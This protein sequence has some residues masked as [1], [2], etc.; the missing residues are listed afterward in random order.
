[1]RKWL[2][3]YMT[4]TPH[5]ILVLLLAATL[6]GS[7]VHSQGVREQSRQPL[8]SPLAMYNESTAFFGFSMARHGDTLVVGDITDKTERG[9][10]RGSVY[11]HQLVD[12]N[13]LFQQ[14][15][16]APDGGE[17][18]QFGYSVALDDTTLLVSAP[19]QAGEIGRNMGA[20][21]VYQRQSGGWTL[22]EKVTLPGDPATNLGFGIILHLTPEE[23]FVTAPV[24]DRG[25]LHTYAREPG[26]LRWTG[27]IA[28]PDL[29]YGAGFATSVDTEGDWMAV[30]APG[31]SAGGASYRQGSVHLYQRQGTNWT[32]Q[33]RLP[34]PD[35][36]TRR[37]FGASVDLAGNR[38]V[39]GAPHDAAPALGVGEAFVYSRT[40]GSW[41]LDARLVAPDPWTDD[42]FGSRV[43]WIG[44]DIAVSSPYRDSTSTPPGGG[45]HFFRAWSNQWAHV[46]TLPLPA[47]APMVPLGA[48][49]MEQDGRLLV[50]LAR[51]AEV[52][53]WQWGGSQ[54]A[55][56]SRFKQP[57]VGL[58]MGRK[59]T[60]RGNVALV[61][62]DGRL[63][64]FLS[65]T[66]EGWRRSG[67]WANPYSGLL[68]SAP[69]DFAL[70]NG[71][72]ALSLAV[73]SESST[74]RTNEVHLY[75][76]TSAG[77]W[78]LDTVLASPS[79]A[80]GFG[81]RLS[82][83]DTALAVHSFETGQLW[84]YDVRASS[85]DQPL[86]VSAPVTLAAHPGLT[87]VVDG[88]WAALGCEDRSSGGVAASGE[89]L[90][91]R[92]QAGGWTLAGILAVPATWR[93]PYGKL[94]ASLAMRGDRLLVG[95]PGFDRPNGNSGSGA[96][97][98][99]EL[100]S[101]SWEFVRALE[102]SSL[103]FATRFGASVALGDHLA[104]VGAPFSSSPSAS[105]GH[106]GWVDVYHE[107]DGTWRHQARF[108]A[109]TDVWDNFGQSI[110]LD[111]LNLLVGAPYANTPEV[112]RRGA[113]H[114]L[115]LS[116]H[117][118]L[119]LWPAGVG[120]GQPW[121]ASSTG[122]MLHL[123]GV[124]GR[125]S[126]HTV[127]VENTGAAPLPL[128][129]L[130]VEAGSLSAFSSATPGATNLAPN[131]SA[132]IELAFHPDRKGEYRSRLAFPSSVTFPEGF[133]FWVAGTAILPVEAWRD[134]H[135]GTQ[136][137]AGEAADDADPDGDGLANLV[138][139]AIGLHP[140]YHDV[141]FL[142]HFQPEPLGLRLRFPHPPDVAGIRYLAET[143]AEIS[144]TEWEP[145]TDLGTADFHE[146]FLPYS[147]GIRGFLRLRVAVAAEVSP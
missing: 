92:R 138:E 91:A 25:A 86:T 51:T 64:H 103:G 79:P 139:F 84:M 122:D 133:S 24:D 23:A 72:A 59:V 78:I 113:A 107:S 34:H 108:P 109:N 62:E 134:Q 118:V 61:S 58:A 13:W 7:R 88:D 17:G 12:G 71:V 40:N 54:W 115:D 44:A 20:V 142:P 105:S 15:L 32:R 27:R 147:S 97:L 77:A 145:L 120:I 41:N 18:S 129:P 38:L 95:V 141:A 85:P 89:V 9:Y 26:G 16:R 112:E 140:W 60:L 10:N 65:Q 75:R 43:A 67:W 81:S 124:A 5:S 131:A 146:F 39:V 127:Q 14:C 101:G 49:F 87:L 119:T 57:A 90:L 8:Y 37:V 30:G 52:E 125:E 123:E 55:R 76:E 48:R 19:G 69:V 126:R 130:Q 68:K 128:G 35:G 4:P 3:N 50:H 80:S 11:V 132:P 73:F 56:R 106:D 104:A 82:L 70:G 144:A 121:P 6:P 63:P 137:G 42:H 21:Y 117:P 47:S 28:P 116:L 83:S 98:L 100:R 114:F 2:H 143:A 29:F 135:F 94:G 66:P 33:I 102:P 74:T 111:G 22:A 136:A 53:E 1:M 46:Q 45:L 99:F 31:D 110:A 96:A 36:L 93:I